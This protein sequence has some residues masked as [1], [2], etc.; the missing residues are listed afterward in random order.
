M[1][2]FTS[3][4]IPTCGASSAHEGFQG[5]ALR[6]DYDPAR[7]WILTEDKI[8]KPKLRGAGGATTRC[9]SA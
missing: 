7:R 9:S 4:A 2:G 5:H 6:K 3:R 1:F 8:Y